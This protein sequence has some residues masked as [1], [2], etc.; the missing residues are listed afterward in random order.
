MK[1]DDI[2]YHHGVKGMKWGIRKA[3]RQTRRAD[4]KDYRR[5]KRANP[6]AKKAYNKSIKKNIKTKYTDIQEMSTKDL[7]ERVN[8]MNLERQYASLLKT[9]KQAVSKGKVETKKLLNRINEQT[10]TLN[11]TKKS[12]TK[13]VGI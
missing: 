6:S 7:Q 4:R 9:Q 11:K 3:S 1:Q 2:L 8:R 13:L 12:V 10:N 5:R